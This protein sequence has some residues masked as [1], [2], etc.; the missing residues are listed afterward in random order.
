MGK[1]IQIIGEEAWGKRDIDALTMAKRLKEAKKLRKN[2]WHIFY[3]FDGERGT[4]AI[5]IKRKLVE[6]YTHHALFETKA[7]QRECFTYAEL[8]QLLKPV[9]ADAK[10]ITEEEIKASERWQ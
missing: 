2:K 8:A 1:R 5:K 3:Q 4:K 6:R 7:G 10:I 9:S